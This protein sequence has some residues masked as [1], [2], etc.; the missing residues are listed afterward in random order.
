MKFNLIKALVIIILFLPLTSTTLD[1]DEHE[2]NDNPNPVMNVY[3]L[4]PNTNEARNQWANLMQN[5]LPKAGIGVT[6][7]TNA[8]WDVVG[9]RTFAY[10]VEDTSV[11][12]PTWEDGGYDMVFIGISGSLAYD[13]SLIHI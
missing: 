3:L 9:P 4:S 10:P 2:Y 1:I 11:G 13:L 7:H 12:I 8:G 5:E 6:G